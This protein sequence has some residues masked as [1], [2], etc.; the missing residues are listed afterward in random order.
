[1]G[2]RC[3]RDR[4]ERTVHDRRVPTVRSWSIAQ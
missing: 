2:D 3:Q 4:T 1:M